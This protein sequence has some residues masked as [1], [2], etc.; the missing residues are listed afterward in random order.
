MIQAILLILK[1]IGIILL[2]VLGLLLLILALVLFVP[3]FY[4][5]RIIRNPQETRIKARVSYLFPL[6]LVTVQ[7][8]KK[9]SYRIRIFGFSVLDS[10]KPEKEKIK[11][12][13]KEKKKK[14]QEKQPEEL[15]VSDGINHAEEEE[16]TFFPVPETPEVLTGE[17]EPEQK[18]EKKNFFGKLKEIKGKIQKLWE[19]IRNVF[20]KIKRLFRQKD[21][22]A[23]VLSQPENKQAVKFAWDKLKHLLKHIFPR[24]TK[25]YLAFGTG[26]PAS[27]GQALGILGVLYAKTGELLEIR[28]DFME[29]RLECDVEFRGRIQ[30]FT[31]LGIIIKVYFNQDIKKLIAAFK[32]IKDME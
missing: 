32:N 5:I 29:K 31:L 19:T 24:K 4:R 21:A 30:V 14:K 12:P 28:P 18:N 23:E 22:V 6:F 20:Y 13:K 10:E 9:L 26:D 1:I 3:V 15:P 8:L 2:A 27:T 25:G 16:D 7:Y 11:K 17:Q